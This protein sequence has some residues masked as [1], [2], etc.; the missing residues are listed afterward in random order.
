MSAGILLQLTALSALVKTITFDNGREFAGHGAIGA[1]LMAAMYFAN[2]YCSW[3]RGLNENTKGLLCQYFR[4]G[5]C[6][7]QIGQVDLDRVAAK[8]NN[9]PRK[10]LDYATPRETLLRSAQ[11]HGVALRA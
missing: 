5:S 7:R 1:A 11:R 10:C 6:F 3:E 2:P 9:R 4:K 8:L